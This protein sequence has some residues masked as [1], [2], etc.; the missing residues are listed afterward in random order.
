MAQAKTLG[1]PHSVPWQCPSSGGTQH[2][3]PNSPKD[4]LG[5]NTRGFTLL[6]VLKNVGCC[7]NGSKAKRITK[8]KPVSCKLGSLCCGSLLP[9]SQGTA[10]ERCKMSPWVMVPAQRSCSHLQWAKE[11]AH[12][13]FSSLH[14]LLRSSP[15]QELSLDLL[16]F[17]D[18]Q[19]H[20]A[21]RRG[22][23][24]GEKW[25]GLSE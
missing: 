6:Q 17:W 3:H 22:H 15:Q 18:L 8:P 1:G 14:H 20:T 2:G 16:S 11:K 21:S 19:W 25:R 7:S 24:K 9:S 4:F 12:T 10:L 5:G 23:G 13:A